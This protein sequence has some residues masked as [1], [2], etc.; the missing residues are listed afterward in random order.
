MPV[1]ASKMSCCPPAMTSRH[2]VLPPYTTVSGPGLGIEPR[3]PQQR[4]FM[5]RGPSPW[6][7]CSMLDPCS[8]RKKGPSHADTTYPTPPHPALDSRGRI[9]DAGKCACKCPSFWFS[10]DLCCLDLGVDP[11]EHV[12]E[13]SRS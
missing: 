1:P 6:G 3:V 12:E 9:L 4:T 5:L 13:G 10:Y 7:A 11:P 2:D 8:T